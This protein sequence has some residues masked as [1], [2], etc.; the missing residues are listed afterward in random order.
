MLFRSKAIT[1]DDLDGIIAAVTE[2]PKRVVRDAPQPV[3]AGYGF[4]V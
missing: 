3:E 4:G 2:R 1:D